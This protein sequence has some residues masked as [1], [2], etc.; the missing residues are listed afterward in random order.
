LLSK[1]KTVIYLLKMDS[2]KTGIP[3]L[4]VFLLALW[5]KI[6]QSCE[7]CVSIVTHPLTL[8]V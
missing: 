7:W 5:C 1:K 2:Y 4:Q 8:L 3:T 6:C